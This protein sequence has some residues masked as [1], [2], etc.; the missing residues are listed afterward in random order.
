M[1]LDNLNKGPRGLK[2]K[3]NKNNKKKFTYYACRKKGYI[4]QD[5]QS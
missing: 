2:F 5:C 1:H 3:H 4:K